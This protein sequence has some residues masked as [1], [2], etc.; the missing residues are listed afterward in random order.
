MPAEFPLPGNLNL[1]VTG[2]V[3]P[4]RPRIARALASRLSLEWV[5]FEQVME[6]RH[7]STVAT[8][9]ATLGERRLQTLESAV[10]DELV[11]HRQACLRI[12][13]STLVHSG[14]LPAL[15]RNGLIVC[16]VASLDATLRRMHLALGARY[17]RVDERA[18][19]LGAL[20]REWKI[21]DAPGIVE[22]DATTISEA[23]LIERVASE[24]RER[25]IRRG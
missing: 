12:P 14:H 23:E 1:V 20:Q 19:A 13:G 4:N 3:E 11:L 16:L 5:D 8:L 2:Y 25:A 22:L 21:R 9:R 15:Q 18:R 10:M 17:Q 6:E 7:G 24:W